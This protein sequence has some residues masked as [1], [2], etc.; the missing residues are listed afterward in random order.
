MGVFV[1]EMTRDEVNDAVKRC[2]FLVL[3]VGSLEQHGPHLPVDTDAFDAT[4]AAADA[5]RE[6]GE[7]HP[8]VLPTI[9]YGVSHH[10]MGFGGTVTVSAE[11]LI[12]TVVEVAESAGALGAK[13]LLLVNGHG[14]NS[15]ALRVAMQRIRTELD[16]FAFMDDCAA[17]ARD[18]GRELFPQFF[19]VHAGAFETSVVLAVR[20]GAVRMERI[21]ESVEMSLPVEEPDKVGFS[22]RME[23]LSRVGVLGRPWEHDVDKGAE[24]WRVEVEK[25]SGLMKTLRGRFGKS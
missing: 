16:M 9:P 6:A 22:F 25:L 24:F 20:P 11:T 13:A 15:G 12:R 10:H 14:G 5:A 17:L 7:P 23:D 19:D 3:P 2:G 18:V 21:P 1:G 4:R 8:P